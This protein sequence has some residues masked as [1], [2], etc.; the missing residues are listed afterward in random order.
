MKKNCLS[1]VPVLAYL[2]E[3]YDFTPLVKKSLES[4]LSESEGFGLIRVRSSTLRMKE[5]AFSLSHWLTAG[6]HLQLPQ[7]GIRS[8]G[9]TEKQ[10]ELSLFLSQSLHY[11]KA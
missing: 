6:I 3:T 9:V 10:Q 11:H 5:T 7:V 8:S 1:V 2:M 4:D